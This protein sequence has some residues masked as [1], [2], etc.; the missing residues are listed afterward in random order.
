MTVAEAQERV[1]AR[2]FAEW[3]AYYS[4][5]PFGEARADYRM[6]ILAAVMSNLW[7]DKGETP[8]RPE[9]FLP[10]FG[11]EADAL[12]RDESAPRKAE[13][14]DFRAAM[15]TLGKGKVKRGNPGPT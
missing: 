2:E 4:L 14:A 12:E 6:G 10:V 13:E 8:T 3:Q 15:L 9:D 7:L 11:A 5:D 1:T